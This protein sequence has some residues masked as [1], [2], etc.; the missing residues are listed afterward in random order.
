MTLTQ[1]EYVLAV[2]KHRHFARAAD[3]CFVTQPTLSMQIK[4]LEEELGVVL[5]DR[6]RQPV[7]P[8]LAAQKVLSL[9]REIHTLG[10]TIPSILNE[11]RVE[12]QGL[13]RLG[14]IPTIAPYL[15]PE[16]ISTL[17]EWHPLLEL[18]IEELTTE[19]LISRLR[20][21]ELDAGLAATP[22]G[23]SGITEI[24]LFNEAFVAFAS[25]GN[26]LLKKRSLTIEDIPVDEL[27]LLS[28]GHCF[29]NQVMNL[30]KKQDK[31]ASRKVHLK[32]AG[33]DTL[34]RMVEKHQGVTLL[35]QMATLEFDE[36]KMDLLRYF[37]S[38]EPVRQVSLLSL[39]PELHHRVL[40]TLGDAVKANV[41]ASFLESGKSVVPL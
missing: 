13:L 20:R 7:I 5:F 23:E 19:V 27:W 1:I 16:V 33:L 34:Q 17:Q 12:L 41:P 14:V 35:P 21:N 25:Q 29:R 6:S 9:M 28:E 22:L 36:R 39:R 32:A 30:C 3:A 10:N 26:A 4:K 18:D 8:T 31:D 40:Q 15:L 2:E 11:S 24:P 37:K 38:P